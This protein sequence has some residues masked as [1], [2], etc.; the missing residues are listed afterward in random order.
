MEMMI[1]NDTWC[2][3]FYLFILSF[4]LSF[5]LNALPSN[6]SPPQTLIHS[7]ITTF[8][9]ALLLLSNFWWAFFFV[10]V[11]LLLVLLFFFPFFFP[12]RRGE[13]WENANPSSSRALLILIFPRTVRFVPFWVVPP[14]F[15]FFFFATRLVRST[16][17]GLIGDASAWRTVIKEDRCCWVLLP[18]L[19]SLYPSS[20]SSSSS[21]VLLLLLFELM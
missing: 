19:S 14:L 15:F 6:P 2:V 9:H 12:N 13:K 10:L 8:G 20:S 11:L 5:S 3:S 7:T 21:F 1:F 4:F 16:T 18:F 17:T